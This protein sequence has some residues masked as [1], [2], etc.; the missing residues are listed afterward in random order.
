MRLQSLLL[1]GLAF[2]LACAT[3]GPPRAPVEPVTD[4]YG[5]TRVV[6][7]YRWMEKGAA[8]PRFEPYLRAQAAYT[9]SVLAP[10]AKQRDALRA[11]LQQLSAGA[12]RVAGWQQAGGRIFFEWLDPAGAFPV[13]RVRDLDGSVRTLLDPTQY[14]D[15]KSHAAID[16]FVPSLDGTHV[17]VGV[18]LGGSENDTLRILETATGRVLPDAISRAQ[19]ASPAWRE[20]GKSFYYGRLQAAP[21]G[22]KPE[23]KY[24]NQRVY[25]HVLGAD[26][27]GDKA[28]FGP[29]VASGPPT[30]IPAYGFNSITVVPGERYLVALHTTGTTDPSAVYVGSE[31]APGW[32]PLISQADHLATSGSSQL[33]LR[34]SQLYALLQ[35]VPNGRVLRYS[36]SS[37]QSKPTTIVPESDKQ[38]EGI[39]GTRDGFYVE[40]R[41]GLSF[42][43]SKLTDEGR[44]L[45]EVA[46]PFEGTV[47]GIDGTPTETGLRFDIESWTRS[48]TLFSY[49]SGS[50]EVTDTG[51]IPKDPSDVSHLVAREVQV[52]S[53]DGASVPVSIVLR[54]DT[55]LDGSRPV[56]MEGYGAYGVSVDPEFGPSMLEWVHRGGILVY[57]HVRGGGELGESWHLAGKRQT[58]QHTVDDMIAAARYLI[59]QKYTSAAHLAARGTSAGGIA[60]GGAIVQHPELFG[61]AVDNVG[62]TNLLRSQLTPGGPGNIPEFGDA[63]RA[64]DFK[65]M[66]PLDA[67]VGVKD[68]TA[69][70]AVIG[71]TGAH[72]PRVEPWIVAKMIARLQA[73]TSSGKPVL[74]RVDF[75]AGHGE[76]SSRTQYLDERADEWTFLLWQLGDPAFQ[77]K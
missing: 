3:L 61:A 13:L 25:L 72:D 71:V 45:G 33:A 68:G 52:P 5:G 6:D 10:L 39:F 30:A 12:G 15:A 64:E 46:L 55:P 23:A 22:S 44:P 65:F 1:L 35:N 37:P 49:H 67:Y 51:L 60:V 41:H 17:A 18:A 56:L 2:P 48:S 58:K 62:A 14:A 24:E 27:E 47:S 70:P 59:D 50:G 53:T 9:A 31:G 73:A 26:P 7:N 63:N 40:Y 4:D 54:D 74:L 20:D 21:A 43:I 19:Y 77:P 16:Y 34:G 36:L 28:V 8:D 75:D 29:G 38:I 69:F 57:A 11:K 76:G 66:L 42:T 32:A